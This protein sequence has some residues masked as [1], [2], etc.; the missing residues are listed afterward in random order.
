MRDLTPL[1]SRD[2]EM[3]GTLFQQPSE[4]EEKIILCHQGSLEDGVL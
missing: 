3:E 1:L 4:T 2:S